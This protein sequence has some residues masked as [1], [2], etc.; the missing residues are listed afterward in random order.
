MT[1]RILLFFLM[2]CVCVCVCASSPAGG[3]PR[4]GFVH[5]RDC[6]RISRVD[7]RSNVRDEE[8]RLGQVARGVGRR[9]VRRT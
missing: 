8:C 6:G 7:A 4:K 9:E 2:L 1:D 3:Y 5:D